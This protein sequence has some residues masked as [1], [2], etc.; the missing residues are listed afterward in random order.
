MVTGGSHLFVE[1]DELYEG[2]RI[3]EQ[4]VQDRLPNATVHYLGRKQDLPQF[5]WAIDFGPSNAG[6]RVA[7]TE[8]LLASPAILRERLADLEKEGKRLSEADVR[9]QWVVLSTVGIA[10]KRPDE[11]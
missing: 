3:V 4:W 1:N 5:R 8:G 10:N 11:W 2:I 7:A 6:F 9:D